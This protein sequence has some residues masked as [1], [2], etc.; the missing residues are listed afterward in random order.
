MAKLTN[1]PPQEQIEAMEAIGAELVEKLGD[2]FF[3]LEGTPS[4]PVKYPNGAYKT[5][6]LI[7]GWEYKLESVFIAVNGDPVFQFS[8]EDSQEYDFV[9]FKV[10]KLDD[11]LPLFGPA[12]AEAFGITDLDS[13]PAIMKRLT[14]ERL[15]EAA[16]AEANAEQEAK[17]AFSNNP[18]FGRFG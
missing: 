12:F 16:L 13:P 3:Q 17:Q 15:M 7:A 1:R 8:P 4:L 18:M 5:K 11:Y 9:D 2:Q 6:P 10:S 14:T